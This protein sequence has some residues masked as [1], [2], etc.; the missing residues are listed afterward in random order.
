MVERLSVAVI[1]GDGIGPEVIAEASRVLERVAELDGRFEFELTTF[2][3]GSEYY[4]RTSQM[5]PD[6]GVEQLSHFDSILLG[7]VG[8]PRVPDDTTLWGLLL[9]IRQRFDQYVN[10]RP[11]RLLPGIATPL[12]NRGPEDLRM[13]IVRENSEGEYS[14]KGAFLREGTSEEMALQIAVFSRRGVVRVLRYAFELARRL[15]V[16]VTSVSKANALNYSGV[17][18]DRML[19]EVEDEFPDVKCRRL[20]VDAA[21]LHMVLDPGRFEVVVGSN[22]FG[23]VLSDLG[24]GLV[25]GLGLAPSAN[26]NPEREHPSMFEPVHGSAPDIVGLGVA[27]PLASIWAAGMMLGHLGYPEWEDAIVQAIENVLSDGTVRTPDLGGFA[28]TID[29][30]DSLLAQ[31]ATPA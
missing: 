31:L 19:D 13:V 17:F 15:E 27:N 4:L 25:G 9:P 11:I 6:D 1:P 10:L 24:A 20:L 16:S 18:W 14:G 30:T 29:V 3:W 21:A 8:D 23:D 2:E 26:L 28:T 12:A 7:A 5:M 22:L